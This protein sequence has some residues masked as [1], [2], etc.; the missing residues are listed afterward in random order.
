MIPTGCMTY[1][2][3]ISF[4]YNYGAKNGHNSTRTSMAPTDNAGKSIAL[5]GCSS[6]SLIDLTVISLAPSVNLR[7]GSQ[8]VTFPSNLTTRDDYVLIREFTA[9]SVNTTS[10]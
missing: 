9:S 5:H 7:V 4:G 2:G 6:S 8:N 1:D 3:F 10:F